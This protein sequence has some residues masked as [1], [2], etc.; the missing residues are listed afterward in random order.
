MIPSDE[1]SW[2]VTWELTPTFTEF[3]SFLE[4]KDLA[5]FMEDDFVQ[6]YGGPPP[7]R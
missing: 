4:A 7:G 1:S 6:R 3:I 2:E 5:D